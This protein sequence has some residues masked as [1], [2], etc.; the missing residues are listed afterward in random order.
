M[1]T[2]ARNIATLSGRRGRRPL[3]RSTQFFKADSEEKLMWNCQTEPKGS[4][5]R[6]TFVLREVRFVRSIKQFYFKIR[7]DEFLP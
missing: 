5:R 7:L 4:A 2:S 1:S 3:Q 6:R